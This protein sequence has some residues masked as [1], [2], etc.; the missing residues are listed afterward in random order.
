M[1][2]EM[3]QHE[4]YAL[5]SG[6]GRLRMIS[7]IKSAVA[8]WR[9]VIACAHY[10]KIVAQSLEHALSKVAGVPLATVAK[11]TIIPGR[12]YPDLNKVFL[13]LEKISPTPKGRPVWKP[14]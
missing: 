8:T 11:V 7:S 5:F 2:E 13:E 6:D 10:K 1:A 12:I 3:Y 4:F 9:R 14:L